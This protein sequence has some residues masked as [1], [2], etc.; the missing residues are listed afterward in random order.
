LRMKRMARMGGEDGNI[1]ESAGRHGDVLCGSRLPWQ[2][3][4]RYILPK[5]QG[6]GV[7]LLNCPPVA[8]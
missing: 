5:I 7:P 3:T 1:R 4:V 6:D 8:E 2:R